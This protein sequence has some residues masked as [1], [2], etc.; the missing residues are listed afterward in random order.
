MTDALRAVLWACAIAG[1]ALWLSRAVVDRAGT[2][3][4]F[5]V[6]FLP[7]VPELAGLTVAVGLLLLLAGASLRTRMTR[8]AHHATID[9]RVLVPV[10]LLGAVA[11]PFLPLLA[12]RMPVV[13]V[14]AGPGRWWVWGVTAGLVVWTLAG[15]LAGSVRQDDAAPARWRR[16]PALA[17]AATSV[18]VFA[19]AAWRLT[20][21]ALY[22]R[23]DEPHYLV[24]AQSLLSDGDLRIDDNHARGDYRDYYAGDLGSHHGARGRHGAV[25]SIHPIGLPVLVAPAFA[26]GGYRAASLTIVACAVMA[27]LLLWTWARAVTGSAAAAAAG[28]LAVAGSASFLLHSFAIYP[29]VPAALCVLVV[30][31]WRWRQADSTASALLRGVVLAAL[32]WLSTKY[33]PMSAGLLLLLLT[34]PDSTRHRRLLAALPWTLSVALWLGWFWLLWGVAS[35]TAPYGGDHQ[36]S[37]GDL[38]TGLPGL[39]FDQEYGIVA[40]APALALAV[41]GWWRLWRAGE[42]RLVAETAAPFALLAL[43]VGAYVMFWGG[44]SAP[45]RQVVA[46]LPLLGVPLAWLYRETRERPVQRAAI[47]FLLLTGTM[48]SATMVFAHHGLLIAN[49]SDGTAALLTYLAPS[50][51]LVRLAPS[52]IRARIDPAPAAIVMTTWLAAAGLAWWAAGRVHASHRGTAA[53]RAGGIALVTLAVGSILVPVVAPGLPS[54]T[55]V[56]ARAVVAALTQYDATARPWAIDYR[57][58]RVAAPE[59]LLPEFVLAG[60]PGLRHAPQPLRV[61]KNMRLALPP[62]EYRVVLEPRPGEALSGDVGLQIGRVGHPRDTWTLDAAGGPWGR[63]FSLDLD[64]SFVGFRASPAFDD[65][66][67]QITVTPLTVLD[68]GRRV[69]RPPVL[70]AAR[71]GGLPFYFHDELAYAEANGFWVRGGGTLRTTVRLRPGPEP[72]GLRLQVHSGAGTTDVRFAAPGWSDVVGLSP[73]ELQQVLVPAL[74]AQRLLALTIAPEQGFVPAKQGG[75]PGDHRVLGCWVEVLPR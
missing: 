34:R 11:L 20:P 36:M 19:G 1:P 47:V 68:A 66:L 45:G 22:P 59:T 29:E 15:D 30:L 10:G 25:Y 42:R 60:A 23:G 8:H 43:T 26:L 28:W 6:V 50:G 38:L 40:Y 70:G 5:R 73:G 58:F 9:G 75:V 55:P 52:L 54:R 69:Q 31:G 71:F 48:V 51:E 24:I 4:G 72:P 35:P 21:S 39:L 2:G 16:W 65:R 56:E 14:L 33:A 46:A 37:V 3:D 32:P 67:A 41:P 53:L 18:V 7:S 13:D 74:P 61:L 62:G 12:N 17:V 44:S 27:V 49:G 57:P 63:T 64:S